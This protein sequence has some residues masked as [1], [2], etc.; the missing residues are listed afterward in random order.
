[1]ASY[2][3]GFSC[4]RERMVAGFFLI[5]ACQRAITSFSKILLSGYHASPALYIA[6]QRCTNGSCRFD[7]LI[8]PENEVLLP[9][10]EPGSIPNRTVIAT[11]RWKHESN[12]AQDEE[13][14]VLTR[15]KH[16]WDNTDSLVQ[17]HYISSQPINTTRDIPHAHL[18]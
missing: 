17:S 12:V 15:S 1:M 14:L 7:L 5:S 4:I 3:N 2:V 16:S 8:V 18:P 11:I 13:M 9:D 10:W 6:S